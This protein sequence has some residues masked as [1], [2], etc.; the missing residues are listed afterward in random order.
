MQLNNEPTFSSI[1]LEYH[2]FR[3]FNSITDKTTRITTMSPEPVT[4][5]ELPVM[6]KGGVDDIIKEN[7]KKELKLAD[8]YG[9]PDNYLDA[10][11]DT[12]WYQW[13]SSI[14]VKPLRFEAKTGKYVMALK[15][16]NHADLGKH[17]HRGEVQVYTVSG[18]WG[19]QE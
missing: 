16:E 18:P 8:E 13:H 1:T 12:L 17:R 15:T 6:V 19:Y 4:Q 10:D 5:S 2:S 7:E 11:K 3:H 14:Y 9:A